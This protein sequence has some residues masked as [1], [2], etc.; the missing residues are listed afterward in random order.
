SLVTPCSASTISNASEPGSFQVTLTEAWTIYAMDAP[1]LPEGEKYSRVTVICDDGSKLAAIPIASNRWMV[2]VPPWATGGT[3]STIICGDGFCRP[4]TYQWSTVKPWHRDA[5]FLALAVAW[6][7]M[8]LVW[9]VIHSR[10][11]K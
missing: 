9:A 11:N 10:R 7:C 1:L 8:L 2:R 4:E 6:V 3:V 5:A